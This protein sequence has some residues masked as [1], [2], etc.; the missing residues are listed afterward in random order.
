MAGSTT[1]HVFCVVRSM[2]RAYGTGKRMGLGDIHCP[3]PIRLSV[4]HFRLAASVT[5]L[6]LSIPPSSLRGS[7][8]CT[9]H[10]RN[11]RSSMAGMAGDGAGGDAPA[12]APTASVVDS[13]RCGQSGGLLWRQ[14]RDDRNREGH[15]ARHPAERIDYRYTRCARLR[16]E[17]RRDHGGQLR[18]RD[19]RRRQTRAPECD[20]GAVV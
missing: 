4:T 10:L 14:W 11:G 8:W 9:D 16:H 20:G 2:D 6:P 3:S 15:R 5:W 19:E 7:G 18:C 12:G 1:G 17:T 13:C